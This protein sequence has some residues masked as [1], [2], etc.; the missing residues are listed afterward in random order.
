MNSPPV[1]LEVPQA[2][3]HSRP[4]THL[5]VRACVRARKCV[6]G[7]GG[8]CFL[9]LFC[10]VFVVCSFDIMFSSKSRS[11]IQFRGCR[12]AGKASALPPVM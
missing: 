12:R 9:L 3:G 5:C 7:G 4:S 11:D 6:R 10:F 8:G 1:Y 2:L